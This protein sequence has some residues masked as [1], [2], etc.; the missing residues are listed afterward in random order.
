MQKIK[1]E[2]AA[3]IAKVLDKDIEDII[4]NIEV[5]KDSSMG[6]F[7]YPCFK[8]SKELRKSPIQIAEDIKC[9]VEY[10]QN[11]SKVEVV[12]GYLN[13]YVNN[14]EVIVSTMKEMVMELQLMELDPKH[15]LN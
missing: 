3:K 5:P 4:C 8:L 7:A 6:D 13:F 2:I 15:H 14:D 12:S 11:I 10:G 1:E 9:K